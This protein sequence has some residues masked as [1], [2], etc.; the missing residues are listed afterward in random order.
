MNRIRTFFTEMNPT[1][2]GFLVIA[3]IA[4]VVVVLQLQQTLTALFLIARIAFF[5]A[6]AVFLFLLWRERRGDIAEWSRRSQIVFYAAALLLVANVGVFVVT[7]DL[8]G[9]PAL[10]FVLVLAICG[11]SMWRVWRDEH[12]YV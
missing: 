9:L 4:L 1:L 12:R 11:F 6:I 7:R 5:I 2:R 3:L 10:S 8:S